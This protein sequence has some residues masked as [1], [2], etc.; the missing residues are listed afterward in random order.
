MQSLEQFCDE[1][2]YKK[3][4][5]LG[6]GREGVSSYNFL[7]KRGFSNI[8]IAD[9]NPLL[10]ENK[11]SYGIHE[12]TTVIAG[13]HYLD[14]LNDY[15]QIIKTPGITLK[16]IKNKVRTGKLN[17]QAEL[18]LGQYSRQVIGVTGTKGKST[19]SA[20]IYALLRS[21]SDDAVLVGNIGVPPFDMIPSIGPETRIVYELSSHQLEKISSSPHISVILNIFQEH[22]DHYEDYHEYQQS[23]FNIFK[24]QH[25]DDFI[26]FNQEDPIIRPIFNKGKYNQ[27][28]YRFTA[29]RGIKQGAFPDNGN[30]VFVNSFQSPVEF[31]IRNRDYLPGR[32]NLMNIMA[33][34]IT[35]KICGVPDDKIE[36]T[37]NNFKG[38]PHRLEYVGVF[39]G[40]TFY[41]DSIA[42]IPEA[43]IHA[44]QTLKDVNTIILGG[45]DRGIDYRP[46]S[47]FIMKSGIENIILTGKAG[48]K[49]REYIQTTQL[50]KMKLYMINDFNEI[51]GIIRNNSRPGSICLLSPA[52]ASYDSFRNF[53][54]RGERFKLIARSI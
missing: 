51:A 12:N 23:K 27:N 41:N 40:I 35:A 18:F 24:Y 7:L 16:V 6:F 32:H 8:T 26:I 3:I 10:G 11:I 28:L 52:A 4:L 49:I 30:V 15:D 29:S 50:K 33:S 5:I 44:V 31:N 54:E 38:L 22:L 9:S 48:L 17:S 37:V 45:V 42:T 13:S 25:P 53:E 20:L 47:E 1:Y 14:S 43:T 34:I 46:L 19:T 21:V 2:R 36:E 39:G